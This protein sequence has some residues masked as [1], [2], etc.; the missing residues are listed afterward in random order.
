MCSKRTQKRCLWYVSG[1][2]LV[3]GAAACY[4]SIQ[5]K[6]TANSCVDTDNYYYSST[7]PDDLFDLDCNECYAEPKPGCTSCGDCG[8]E[9]FS[10]CCK[11]YNGGG[12][13]HETYLKSYWPVMITGICFMG[14]AVILVIAHRC[15]MKKDNK[16]DAL[17]STLN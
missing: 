10:E 9:Y 17:L 3:I 12:S 13:L 15:K 14:V 2:F 1:I 8:N 6:N 5:M 16:P 4:G 11:S 7:L